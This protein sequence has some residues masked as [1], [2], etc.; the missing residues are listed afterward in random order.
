MNC[1]KSPFSQ[2]FLFALLYFPVDVTLFH[3][4]GVVTELNEGIRVSWGMNFGRLRTM[5]EMTF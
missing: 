5:Q 2:T 3:L 4:S 1:W